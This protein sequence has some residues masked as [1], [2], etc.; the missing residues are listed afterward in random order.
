MP[1]NQNVFIEYIQD[2]TGK[3]F[4]QK[5]GIAKLNSAIPFW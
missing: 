4:K 1:Q 3:M 2:V 5:S